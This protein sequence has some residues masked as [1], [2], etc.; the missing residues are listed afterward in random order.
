MSNL[1]KLVLIILLVSL[2][3]AVIFLYRV[4]STKQITLSE[5]KAT[6]TTNPPKCLTGNESNGMGSEDNDQIGEMLGVYIK[7]ADEATIAHP[8]TMKYRLATN[9][10]H[11]NITGSVTYPENI[12]SYNFAAKKGLRWKVTS[13]SACID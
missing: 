4:T 6:M 1:R 11:K 7:E 10:M 13:F 3:T 2:A 9:V 8:N 5:A 12:G